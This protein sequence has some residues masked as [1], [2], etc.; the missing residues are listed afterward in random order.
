MNAILKDIVDEKIKEARKI[1]K[2]VQEKSKKKPS[3][4][5]FFKDE[6]EKIDL[7]SVAK[8]PSKNIKQLIPDEAIDTMAASINTTEFYKA[9][10]KITLENE[11]VMLKILRTLSEIERYLLYLLVDRKDLTR[12]DRD[13]QEFRNIIKE[14]LSIFRDPVI[15]DIY[16]NEWKFDTEFQVSKKYV[17]EN[18][19]WKK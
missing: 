7:V 17:E 6:S 9:N 14:R 3:T 12:L 18:R 5:S 1:Q 10:M 8:H 11:Y 2:E 15:Q 19:A 13:L 4:L 16:T